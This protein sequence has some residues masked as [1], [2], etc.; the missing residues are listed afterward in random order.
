[1]LT[2]LKQIP[3]NINNIQ[4]SDTDL[5]E[6]IT[7]IL[8]IYEKHPNFKGKPSFKKWCNYCRRYG[9][10]ISEC[11]QKQQDNQNKPQ[12]YKEPNKSF[13]QYMKKDQNLPNKSVYSNNRTIPITRELNHHI[14]Q[15]IEE[16]HQNEEIH[17][18]HHKTIIIDQIVEI[19]TPDQIQI[20]H[21]LS[22]DLIPN[23]GIITIQTINHETHHTIEIETTPIIEIEVIQT[24]ETRITRTIDQGITHI[25]DKTITDQTIII[26]TDHEIIHKIDIQVIITVIEIIPNHHT[27]IITIIIILTIATEVVHPN[28]KK[29]LIKYNQTQKQHQTPQVLMTQEITNYN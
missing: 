16:D 3:Q 2:E 22:L 15:V 27:G 10:S 29:I 9:H 17:K 25:I 28:I 4:E 21:N 13:Y 18:I 7:E 12:K 8:N 26:K 1:M 19:T 14:T 6:K 24:T 23:Q 11:R 20:Q 5:V